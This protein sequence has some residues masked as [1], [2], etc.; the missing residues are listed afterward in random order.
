MFQPPWSVFRRRLRSAGV[1]AGWILPIA[2]AAGP[3]HPAVKRLAGF[4][5]RA[6]IARWKTLDTRFT[7]SSRFVTQGR[8]SARLDFHRYRGAS[9]EAAWPRVT[10]YAGA[11]IYPQDWSGWGAV[12]F[13][14]ATDAN[15]NRIIDFSVEIRDA[16]GHNGWTRNY[17]L[18]PNSIQ[19]IEIPLRD[20]GKSI[21]LEHI[22]EFLIFKGRPAYDFT[23]YIDNLRLETPEYVEAR[24]NVR[25]ARESLASLWCRGGANADLVEKIA[26]LDRAAARSDFS[27]AEARRLSARAAALVRA[28][29]A[30]RIRPLRAFDFGPPGSPVRPGFQRVTP[31]MAFTPERGYG[32]LSGRDGLKARVWPAARGL[33]PSEYYGR[34]IPPP[35]YLIDLDQDVVGGTRPAEFAIRVPPGEY[36]VWLLAG[37][38]RGWTP[39]VN[40]FSVQ[41]GD[42]TVRIAIPQENIFRETWIRTRVDGS[43]RLLLRFRPETGFVV[44]ALAVFPKN[45]ERRARCEF[46]RPIEMEIFRAP[47]EIWKN[48]RLI[49]HAPEP[50]SPPPGPTE[51]RRGFVLFHRPLVRNVYPDSHP[52]GRERFSQLEIQA[53]PGEYEPWTFSVQALRDL[54]A[55]SV[56]VVGD[57]RGP[58]G[59]RIPAGAIDVRQVRCW[60]VRTNYSSMH[61]YKIVPELLDPVRAA[62]LAAGR[63]RRYWLTVHVPD[64]A[65]AGTYRGRAALHFGGAA[66]GEGKGEIS[67]V[68]QVLPFK[69]LRDPNRDFGNYYRSPL[70]RIR[71]GMPP[72]VIA[73]LRRRAEAEAADMQAHGMTTVQMPSLWARKVDGRWR[74]SMNLT[75]KRVAFLR[76][77]GLWGHPKGI[78]MPAF[79]TDYLYTRI[80]GKRWPKHLRGAKMPPQK[81]FD[82]ITDLIAQ[83]EKI[84]IA[85][86]WP[87]FY[88]Y[89]I[90]EAAPEAIPLLARTLAAVKKVATAK[91]Y[92]TQVFELP[93][94]RPLDPV[95]DVWCSAW[96]CIDT[97]AVA[98]MRKKGRIFWCYPNFVACSRGVPNSARMTYG[99]GV[100]R[101]GYSCL[102]PW[103]YQAP[104]GNP[105][106]D[107]DATFGDWCMAYPGPNGPI[108]TQ[109]WE[110]VREGIDD[111][112]YVYTLEARIA[113]AQKSGRR[114]KAVAA[115]RALLRE[116]RNA[117]PVRKKYLQSG[118]WRGPE[119]DHW[120]R[121]L[122]AA[123]LAFQ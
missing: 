40:N 54:D 100:W 69:L 14:A 119:Y 51:R 108:P 6:E 1:F 90:D 117:V 31:A 38:P 56:A 106:T 30:R 78:M 105:F 81:F 107:F 52:Q 49:P 11:G 17:I 104:C 53:T 25:L 8:H 113:A 27:V 74:V 80:M 2:A 10:A 32:W 21:H 76:R 45:Q 28:V 23:L 96:F 42:Q 47:P 60:P 72:A 85:R 95:L 123:I 110:A 29:A 63:C 39:F 75:P 35:V 3:A 12:A 77:F 5:S 37:I 22:A 92:A 13:D 89:P 33:T 44:D 41:A 93:Y 73:A 9:G 115:G 65:V 71:S 50:A 109:R 111:G 59:A 68:L 114:P 120:R 61:T 122:A 98:A 64:S 4:E 102:I 19:H 34:P 84:R 88:Y 58:G 18:V 48:W 55:L 16:R 99:F 20:V 15:D 46:A 101:M 116:L 97:K 26:E 118:P 7:L 24:R 87:D 112:R 67:L 36:V 94:N 121:R 79:F 70:D 43:G 83:S 62:D 103:H 91:T 86:G 82:I 57:L 66:A